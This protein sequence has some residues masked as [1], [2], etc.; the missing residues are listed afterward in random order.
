MVGIKCLRH[1]VAYVYSNSG[2][3]SR[4]NW[5]EVS[6]NRHFVTIRDCEVLDNSLFIEAT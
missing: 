4:E 1:R 3:G 2:G 6:S 5:G